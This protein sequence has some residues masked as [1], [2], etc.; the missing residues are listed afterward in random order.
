MPWYVLI[1][2]PKSEKKVAKHLEDRGVEVCCPVRVEMRQ[3]S[4]RK[5][6][7]EVPLLPSMV[8]VKLNDAER[9]VVFETPGAV[10]YLFWLGKPATVSA[11]EIEALMDIRNNGMEV[12]GVSSMSEGA[13]IDLKGFGLEP[14][15]G[16]IKYVSGNQCWVVLHNLGYVIKLQI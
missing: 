12:L 11:E 2:K 9:A 4:D 8:L 14:A 5:K 13:E 6:K 1:T 16:T 15:K 7:V 10:R 3:W